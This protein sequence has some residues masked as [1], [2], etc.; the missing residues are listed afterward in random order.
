VG[1]SS[2]DGFGAAATGSLAAT[3]ALT[4][5]VSAAAP[6]PAAFMK[7][8]R[9]YSIVKPPQTRAQYSNPQYS[10]Q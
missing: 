8:R 3:T 4:V 10:N 2:G 6:T 9:E 1:I 7:F 5:V